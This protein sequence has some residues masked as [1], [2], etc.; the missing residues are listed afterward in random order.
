MPD[1]KD[2]IRR[3][4]SGL[5]LEPVQEAEI[6]EELAQHLDDVYQRSIATGLSEH[7][8]KRIALGE[9]ADGDA[10]PHQLKRVHK[11]FHEAPVP[12]GS[13]SVEESSP[14]RTRS[15]Y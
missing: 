8:S 11:P 14:P 2:E 1:W 7:E 13:A 10:L 4:L 5:K 12:G 9:L 3:R 15:A 6:V